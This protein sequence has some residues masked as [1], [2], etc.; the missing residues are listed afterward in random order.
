MKKGIYRLFLVII[1]FMCLILITFENLG[2]LHAKVTSTDVFSNVSIA[3]SFALQFSL[4]LS[5]GIIFGDINFLPATNVNASHNYDGVGNSTNL[6]INVSTDGNS[7][8]DFCIM[9]GSGLMNIGGDE[10]GLGNET[11]STY[12]MSN[13][14][15]PTLNEI[16][17]SQIYTKSGEN[18]PLGGINYW[19]FWLDVPAG[20]PSGNYNN[21]VYF[22]AIE[23]GV[24]C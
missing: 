9:G 3:K 23:T 4:G 16:S 7:A 8:V 18:I 14:T 12:N 21:T 20:Q 1:L 22:K 11:Y 19:R 2:N 13:F 24:S 17:L 6:Y 15:H 5:E 10:I